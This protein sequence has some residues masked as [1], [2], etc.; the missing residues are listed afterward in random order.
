MISIYLS[1]ITYLAVL[2]AFVQLVVRVRLHALY[3]ERGSRD[4]D[5][6]KYSREHLLA[7][8]NGLRSKRE[9]MDLTL[10]DFPLRNTILT[11]SKQS[12]YILN[13]DEDTDGSV[14]H[15]DAT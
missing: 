12:R 5:L 15:G 9:F 8:V 3:L 1:N 4:P 6:A 13:L 11:R 10:S 14:D 7:T 2:D